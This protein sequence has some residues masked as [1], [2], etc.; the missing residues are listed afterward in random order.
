M[1][2]KY[3]HSNTKW[4]IKNYGSDTNCQSCIQ[5]SQG[6]DTIERCFYCY[7]EDKDF[8]S[9]WYV[10]DGKFIKDKSYMDWNTYVKY[11]EFLE[12]LDDHDN[13]DEYE[14]TDD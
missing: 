4:N 12:T 9:G 8:T 6:L 14:N 5:H 3:I 11:R 10:E 7:R 13:Y 1:S 2:F